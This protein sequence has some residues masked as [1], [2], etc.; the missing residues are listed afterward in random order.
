MKKNLLLLLLTLLPFVASA[1]PVE[2]DGIY[3]ILDSWS[4]V[5]T[6]TVTS[7][8]DKY[9]GYIV[10]PST[11]TYNDVT[12][13]VTSIGVDAFSYCSGLTSVTIPESMT[14]ID[15]AAFYG[16]SGLTSITIPN[17]VTSIGGEAFHGTAWYN[18]QPEG[19]VY[20]GSCVYKYKGKM[21]ANTTISLKEGT[22][23][24]A[25][26]AFSDCSGL[27]SVTIPNSVTSIGFRAFYGCSGLTSVTIPNSV[28]SMGGGAF[29]YCI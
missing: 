4:D 17:S 23:G 12:Y 10:I 3:Y 8:P 20:A 15:Q 18:N 14:S 1:D 24:I 7:N 22:I 19:L 2:I 11:F 29:Y 26:L 16:C 5:K 6:A 27:T 9:S 25:D 28:T 21:P 13:S